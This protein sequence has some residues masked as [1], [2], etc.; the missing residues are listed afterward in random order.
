[1]SSQSTSLEKEILKLRKLGKDHIIQLALKELQSTSKPEI[2]EDNFHFIQVM[3]SNKRIKVHFGYNVIYFP[4]NS[5]YNTDIIVEFPSKL[6]SINSDN[7]EGKNTA[8]YH[9][10][11]EHMDVI[12]FILNRNDTNNDV[13]NKGNKSSVVISIYE[14]ENHYLVYTT[15]RN[16]DQGGIEYI[17]EIHKETGEILS[18]LSGHYDPAPETPNLEE[19]KLIEIDNK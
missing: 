18:T 16:P 1:M 6:I 2:T 15:S 19:E 5:S 7:N 10:T 12:N 14:K 9:P 13:F 8:F 3:A 11:S 4:K 17:E